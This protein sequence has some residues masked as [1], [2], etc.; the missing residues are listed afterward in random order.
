MAGRPW[1]TANELL[2]FLVELVALACLFWWGFSLA[3]HLA[4]RL[5]LGCAVLAAA[6]ALWA[7]FAAPRAR[8]R[9]PLAG[10]L[11]VKALVLGGGAS[12]LYGVG[13]P[14]AAAALAVVVVVNTALAE[15]FRRR[16]APAS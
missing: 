8:F 2:A 12:A 14:T 13:H 1:W 6:I 5:P 3:D 16:P 15:T 4:V 9:P 10:V 7:L 11:A